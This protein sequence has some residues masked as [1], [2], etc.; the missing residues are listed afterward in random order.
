MR[1]WSPDL[2]ARLRP[3]SKTLHQN[4]LNFEIENDTEV[5]KLT[6]RLSELEAERKE[7][8]RLNFAG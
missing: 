3:K 2:A 8:K 5:T 1:C 6:A 7:L 4:L